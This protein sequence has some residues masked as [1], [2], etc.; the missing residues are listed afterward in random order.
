MGKRFYITTI[1][2]SL[3]TLLILNRLSGQGGL[4]AKIREIGKADFISLARAD[5][6][7]NLP[8]PVLLVTPRKTDLGPLGP[9]ESA[10][11]SFTLKN[12]GSGILEWSTR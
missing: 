5:T 6:K 12:L 10:K 2:V 11:V 8:G 9:G 1:T 3:L 4:T 7:E